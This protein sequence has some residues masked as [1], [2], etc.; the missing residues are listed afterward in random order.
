MSEWSK[1]GR[2]NFSVAWTFVAFHRQH[3]LEPIS[4]CWPGVQDTGMQGG[5]PRLTY[6]TRSTLYQ[7]QARHLKLSFK[8]KVWSGCLLLP[9]GEKWILRILVNNNQKRSAP[10]VL[11][12]SQY[13]AADVFVW[14]QQ[15]TQLFISTVMKGWCAF[16]SC[17]VS[18]RSKVL[19]YK[20]KRL[21]YFIKCQLQDRDICTTLYPM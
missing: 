14:H 21:K 20:L 10:W 3:K 18:S 16:V 7:S 4:G 15:R 8:K 2:I 12:D 13:L 6:T 1:C 9:E 5:A 11:M 17:K 19:Y